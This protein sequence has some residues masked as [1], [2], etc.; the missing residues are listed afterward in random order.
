MLVRL[1]VE[2]PFTSLLTEHKLLQQRQHKTLM[3]LLRI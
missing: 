1:E 3:Q 2:L